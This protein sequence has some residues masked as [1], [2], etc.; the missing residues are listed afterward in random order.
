MVHSTAEVPRFASSPFPSEIEN[1]PLVLQVNYFN[2]I[3]VKILICM[4]VRTYVYRYT[5]SGSDAS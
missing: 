5:H 3:T 4:H 1:I 2:K